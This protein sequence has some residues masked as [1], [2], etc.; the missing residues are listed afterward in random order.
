MREL[1]G[2]KQSD[3]TMPTDNK[4]G[5][6]TSNTSNGPGKE[7]SDEGKPFLWPDIDS[8]PC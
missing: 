7:V 8:N 6:N 5:K 1:L 3:A 2:G 4:G